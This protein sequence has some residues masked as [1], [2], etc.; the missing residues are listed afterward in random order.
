MKFNSITSLAPN[1]ITSRHRKSTCFTVKF[2]RWFNTLI[3]RNKLIKY[4]INFINFLSL[5][6]FTCKGKKEK[7][8]LP[9]ELEREY[10][11]PER[12][13]NQIIAVCTGE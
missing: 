10:V 11:N 7:K 5:V 13:K 4:T 2:K 3:N 1:H 9:L 12:K 6:F 8:K